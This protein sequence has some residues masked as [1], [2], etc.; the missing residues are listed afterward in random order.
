MNFDQFFLKLLISYLENRKQAV[1]IGDI[2]SDFK[3]IK[4][5][6]PQGG[7]LSSTF[8]NIYIN[9]LFMLNLSGKLTLYCDDI[10]LVNTAQQHPDLKALDEQD[11]HLISTWLDNHYLAP[12]INKTKYMLFHGRKKFEAF[13]ELALN[14]KFK[15]S[16]VERVD[17]F[18]LLGLIIDEN[19]S[20]KPH[21]EAIQNK[22]IPFV[23]AL[24]RIRK[25]L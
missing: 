15:N 17:S 3:E 7:V 12:N 8:F 14:I 20:F 5:G 6:T 25:M 21:I 19:L 4:S 23:Y 10:S 13:T 1:K 24:R 2:L 18:K 11:L 16:V 9:S 22:I